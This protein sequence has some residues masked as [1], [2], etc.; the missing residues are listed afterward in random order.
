MILT[1]E[2]LLRALKNGIYTKLVECEDKELTHYNVISFNNNE[3]LICF[4]GID[5]RDGSTLHMP[6]TIKQKDKNRKWFFEKPERK[7]K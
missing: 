3:L 6:H 7:K 5:W 4:S 1:D 2:E